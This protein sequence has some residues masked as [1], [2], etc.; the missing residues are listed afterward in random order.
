[1]FPH[2]IQ[3]VYNSSSQLLDA[4]LEDYIVEQVDVDPEFPSGFFDGL[5][6]NESTT[7]RAAPQKVPG[8][9]HAHISEFQSNLV[10][11]GIT[12]SSVDELQVQQP[13]PGLPTVHWV[14]LDNATLGVKQLI[15]EFNTE[16]IVGDAPPQW[17][18][19]VIQWVAQNLNKPITHLWVSPLGPNLPNQSLQHYQVT[20]A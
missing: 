16:V 15:I 6:E 13:V 18:S 12:N 1:M 8:I 11:A 10:W 20:N 2:S 7:P 3:T 4:T 17:T 14:V 19:S 5:A 9:S